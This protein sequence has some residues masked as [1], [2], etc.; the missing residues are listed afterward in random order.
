MLQYDLKTAAGMIQFIALFVCFQSEMEC[1]DV[2]GQ[3]EAITVHNPDL[4]A[5]TLLSHNMSVSF[6]PIGTAAALR[7]VTSS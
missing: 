4:S 5:Q 3:D 2:M 1:I 6:G 7:S